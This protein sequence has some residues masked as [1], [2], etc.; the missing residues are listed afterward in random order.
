MAFGRYLKPGFDSN[1]D[2]VGGGRYSNPFQHQHPVHFDGFLGDPEAKRDL[3]VELPL[4]DE[5]KDLP[6]SAGKT[7]D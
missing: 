6:L 3:F 7:L 2:C 5:L 4:R 1:P